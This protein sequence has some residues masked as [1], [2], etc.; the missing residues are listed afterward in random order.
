[1]KKKRWIVLLILSILLIV[2]GIAA[3]LL[4]HPFWKKPVDPGQSHPQA[5]TEART[6]ETTQAPLTTEAPATTEAP[7]TEPPIPETTAEPLPENPVDFEALQE[8]NPDIYAWFY[9]SLSPERDDIDLPILQAGIGDDD[10]FYL[11]HDIDRT[12]LYE[13]SLYTQKANAKDF[14]DRM[15][16]IYGHNM[17]NQSRFSNLLYLRDPDI[18]A[19]HEY[20]YIYTPGH[21][22]T[23]RIA[24]AI[25]FDKRHLLN[26]FD[27]SDDQ[28]FADWIDSYILHPK[29][30]VRSVR[31]GMEVTIEDRIVVLSTCI[32]R[33]AY[34]YLVQGVLIDDALTQ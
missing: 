17:L 10:N 29:S 1:M 6:R 32:E 19:S 15:T 12:Y 31:E 33:G 4:S 34:R 16:V 25:Q 5:T 21:I 27:F 30:Y 14:S 23:Y 28:V 11:H 20:F 13:G 3:Y 9:M 24:C 2:G 18:F 22:L 7:V 8:I 26:C